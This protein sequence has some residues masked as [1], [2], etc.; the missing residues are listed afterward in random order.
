MDLLGIL[1]DNPVGHEIYR[2]LPWWS[3]LHYLCQAAAILTLEL[4]LDMRHFDEADGSMVMRHLGKAALYLRCL[5]EGSLSAYKAWR[6]FQHFVAHIDAK[7]DADNVQR[8]PELTPPPHGWTEAD[9][10]RLIGAFM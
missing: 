5:A 10:S 3:L 2:F 9:E 6:I 1:P 7:Y 4:C 8:L